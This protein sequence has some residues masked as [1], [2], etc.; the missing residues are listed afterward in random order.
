MKVL[1]LC[2]VMIPKIAKHWLSESSYGGWITGIANSIINDSDMKLAICFP[3][4]N[5]LDV[6]GNV[7]GIDYFGFSIKS[8]RLLK[9]NVDIEKYFV[10]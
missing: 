2:N 1:W 7:D 3:N 9:Y 8:N 4:V 5:K 10:V 6:R